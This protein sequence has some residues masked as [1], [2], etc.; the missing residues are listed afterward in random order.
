M[1][2]V[3]GGVGMVTGGDITAP[4]QRGQFKKVS[5]RIL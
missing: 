4:T 2:E 1:M 3:D 5:A